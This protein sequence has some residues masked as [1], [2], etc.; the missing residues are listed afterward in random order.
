M[1]GDKMT[2]L[3]L[4]AIGWPVACLAAVSAHYYRREMRKAQF[5]LRASIVAGEI[6]AE[7]REQALAIAND[8]HRQYQRLAEQHFGTDAMEHVTIGLP[9]GPVN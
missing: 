9:R 5:E 1:V 6:L 3:I 2:P 7:G 8:L 4:A